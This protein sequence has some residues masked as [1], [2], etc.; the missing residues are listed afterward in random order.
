VVQLSIFSIARV[1]L[2]MATQVLNYQLRC[3]TF[4]CVTGCSFKEG[5]SKPFIL[6]L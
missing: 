2:D 6:L 3:S 5:F 1:M 4:L